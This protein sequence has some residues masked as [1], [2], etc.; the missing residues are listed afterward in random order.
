MKPEKLT[1]RMRHNLL[2][3]HV[4]D[5]GRRPKKSCAF[6]ILPKSFPFHRGRARLCSREWAKAVLGK[7]SQ[8]TGS[9]GG[10]FPTPWDEPSSYI[11]CSSDE[12][13]DNCGTRHTHLLALSPDCFGIRAHVVWHAM[14]FF[15]LKKKSLDL[16][17]P[18]P[19]EVL[20]PKYC[21]KA[22][23][24]NAYGCP[25]VQ[26]FRWPLGAKCLSAEVW[27]LTQL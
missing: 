5:W 9:W 4:K 26:L 21:A 11:S 25:K 10:P 14:A 13:C 23:A 6:S 19:E 12:N 16:S 17:F 27:V 22:G 1:D 20:Y 15:S 8:M 24:T 2:S 7:G 3:L 18:F